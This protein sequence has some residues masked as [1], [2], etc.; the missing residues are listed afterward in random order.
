MA[1]RQFLTLVNGVVQRVNAIISSAGAADA[2]KIV[3]TDAAGRL[4]ISLMP[5]GIGADSLTVQAS[6]NL[7]AG[8]FVNIHDVTGAARVRKASAADATK[9][10]HGFV[11]NSV[12]SGANAT[13][14]FE[15]TNTALT[16]LTIGA[17][18]ILSPTTPGVAVVATTALSA[19][20]VY[21][22]VGAAVSTTSMT[23]EINQPITI[24]A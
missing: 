8:D 17:E 9:P 11:L 16:G 2:N 14:F 19:G 21:Q 1:V 22:R 12:T 15:G 23:T 18:Y 24:V 4:D 13:V 3:A 7:A 10:A 5:V 6:E 20:Q